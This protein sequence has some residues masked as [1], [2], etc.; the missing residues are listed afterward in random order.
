[1]LRARHALVASCLVALS[2]CGGCAEEGG[3]QRIVP[4][5]EVEPESL[6]FGDV[7]VGATKR[8]RVTVRSVG[9]AELEL[10]GADTTAPFSVSVVR[11]GASSSVMAET[12]RTGLEVTLD[13]AFAPTNTDPQSAPLVVRSNDP[14]R[15]TLAIPLSGTGVVGVVAVRP[16]VIEL[17][18]TSVGASRVVELVFSNLGIEEVSGRLVTE[19]FARPEH[20]GLTGFTNIA[21]PL[22][23]GLAARS[24]AKL[25]LDYHP[26]ASGADDGRLV[27]ELCGE[28]CG[29]EVDV[30]ASAIEAVVRIDPPVIDFGTVGIGMTVSKAVVVQNT[31]MMPISVSSIAAQGSSEL[32][33]QASR[34]LPAV[35]EGNSSL[36][37][38]LEYTPVSAAALQGDL[39]VRTTDA[40]VPEATVRV[41]GRGAGPLFLVQPELLAFGVQRRAETV[42]RALLLLNAG[43]ADVQVHALELAGEGY[44]L[45]APPGLPVRLGSG[46]SLV[47]DVLFS[48][49]E[50]REY[51][52]TLTVRTDDAAKPEVI[53][54]LSGGLADRLCELDLSEGRVNFGLMPVGFSRDKT[55]T[56]TNAGTDPCVLLSGAFR[57]PI[58]PSIAVDSA[59][60]PIFPL[61]LAQGQSIE[62]PFTFTPTLPVESKGNFVLTTADPV[63]PERHLALLGSAAGYVDVFTQ[64]ASLDFGSLRPG[65][66]SAEREVRIF[67]AGTVDVSVARIDWVT[68]H[69]PELTL[70]V[71]ALPATV[72]AGDSRAFDV[73]FGPADLGVETTAV[74][75]EIAD[76]PYPIIVPVRAEGSDD[77]RA[78]DEFLQSDRQEVD[79]LFVI[80]D[81][82]SMDDEQI[83]LAQNFRN[84]IRQA[85]LRDVEFHLGITT[86][87]LLPLPGA[88]VGP[89]LTPNT[90][91]LEREFQAQVGVGVFGSGIEQGLDAMAGALNLATLNVVPNQDFRR[92]SAML[93]TIIVSD[94]DDQSASAPV[95][96]LNVLRNVTS[97]SGYVTA[98]VSGQGGGCGF[99]TMGGG[100][101]SAPRYEEFVRLT[102]GMSESICGNWSRTLADLGDAAFGLRQV[103]TLSRDA[104]PQAP[105]IV[106]LDGRAVPPSEFTYDPANRTIRFMTAPPERTRITV[107]YTPSC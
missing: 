9:A 87:T 4:K 13:V 101:T 37:I 56:L 43:S 71:G 32:T 49:T 86:T 67:N 60:A 106:E 59:T 57:A 55:V 102:G 50:V 34:G 91:N 22:P 70:S 45:R 89:V 20:V 38:T 103:F 10:L 15:P 41:V 80:D 33:A 95:Y 5:V 2:G 68:A 27:F 28:R 92:P 98:V 3:L 8:L 39:V 74:Q 31:G 58:D 11:E 48:P 99:N 66:A 23:F 7:P 35:L 46:Q 77:P 97:R 78:I 29:V 40:A 100:A 88:F 65:C 53:V 69:S 6:A 17:T 25:D 62:L 94:E 81:S 96:F 61:T 107:E 104:D 21:E 12:L 14:E 51:L 82:C 72:P 18:D 90:P 73:A 76:L 16:A 64:P 52:G 30:R 19:G 79:V 63:F 93:V 1:M 47:V 36:A 24:D 75:V 42:R 84:F 85:D 54:P 83:A 44:A 105:I 26:I